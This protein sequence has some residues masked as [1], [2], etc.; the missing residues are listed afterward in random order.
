MVPSFR[1]YELDNVRNMN[2]NKG[3]EPS[4][5]AGEPIEDNSAV[6]P[7]IYIFEGKI[8]LILYVKEQLR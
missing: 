5:V 1:S 7:G 8:E 2:A 4:W 3:C 6:S